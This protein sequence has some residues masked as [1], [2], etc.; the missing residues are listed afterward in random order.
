MSRTPVPITDA[1]GTPALVGGVCTVC[2][3]H[4]FP[5]LRRCAKCGNDCDDAVLPTSGTLWTYTVQRLQPKPP[6]ES[7]DPFE[8]FGVGYVDLGVV[9]VE[10]PLVGRDVD[11]WTIG[12]EVELVAAKD[13]DGVYASYAFSPAGSQS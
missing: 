13:A 5:K 1:G 2:G 8:P 11:A 10:T 9:R 7:P 4:T 6:Y 12:D 3:T